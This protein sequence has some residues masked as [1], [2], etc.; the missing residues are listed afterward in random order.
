VAESLQDRIYHGMIAPLA[1]LG[2]LV[3]AAKRSMKGQEEV[4][5]PN[6]SPPGENRQGE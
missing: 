1:F 6:D 3:F 4:E 2:V 5:P